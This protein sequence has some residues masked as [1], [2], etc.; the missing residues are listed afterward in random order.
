VG[1]ARKQKLGDDGYENPANNLVEFFSDVR[2]VTL[3]ISPSEIE[4]I[5]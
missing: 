2:L 5:T 4:L 3:L 1:K